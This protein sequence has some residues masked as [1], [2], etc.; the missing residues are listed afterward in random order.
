MDKRT[1]IN[2]LVND[3]INS[4]DGAKRAKPLPYLST[5]VNARLNNTNKQIGQNQIYFIYRPS[6][7]FGALVFLILV[8]ITALFLNERETA[9]NT[10]V[11]SVNDVQDETTDITTSIY[12]IVNTEP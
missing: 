3:A 5:R 4:T 2:Q 8:N 9:L 10:V 6:V 1:K 12:D 7:A 11:Q